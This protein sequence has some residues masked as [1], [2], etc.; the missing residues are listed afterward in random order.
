[1]TL[2]TLVVFAMLWISRYSEQGQYELYS[3]YFK[4]HSLSGLQVDSDVTMRGIQ[5][6]N[7]DSWEI[8]PRDIQLVK[9]IIR[10]KAGNPI[11]T[12]TKAII[13]RN[14]LTGIANIDLINSTQAAPALVQILPDEPY[15]II[16]EGEGSLDSLKASLPEVLEKTSTMFA[17]LNS[18]LSKENEESF[19]AILQNIKTITAS[20]SGSESKL[21]K[22]MSEISSMVTEMKKVAGNLGKG[23][24]VVIKSL[25]T[26]LDGISQDLAVA[27]K[28]LASTLERFQDPGAL[29]HG[30]SQE[31]LGPG[32][33]GGK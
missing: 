15:P 3:I 5:I 29:I 27:T 25:Q 22:L 4:N 18:F 28:S 14:L 24:E 20:A 1:M 2:V 7:V 6:G 10:T 31:A 12:D 13:N 19:T 16:P 17:H 9:V 21:S 30:P 33:E 26:N 8:S 11:K 32:E 23:S